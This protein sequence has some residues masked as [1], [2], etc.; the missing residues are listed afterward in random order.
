MGHRVC[1]L[2]QADWQGKRGS[3]RVLRVVLEARASPELLPQGMSPTVD[4]DLAYGCEY[5]YFIHSPVVA[6]S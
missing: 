3:Q 5:C 1:G 2:L 6:T 4:A